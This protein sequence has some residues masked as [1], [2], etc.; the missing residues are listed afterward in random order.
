[1]TTQTHN[2]YLRELKII[3]PSR[4]AAAGDYFETGSFSMVEGIL[5]R[6]SVIIP[7]T[8]PLLSW[9]FLFLLLLI[10]ACV[11]KK[12]SISFLRKLFLYLCFHIENIS[13]TLY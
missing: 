2:K 12:L 1:M 7:K 8:I 4:I 9:F 11:W 5:A 6:T 13:P 10:Q 3:S